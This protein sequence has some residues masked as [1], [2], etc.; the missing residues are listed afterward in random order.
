MKKARIVKEKQEKKQDLIEIR[1]VEEM[2]S[3]RF[4]K[5]LKMS[6]KKIS[7][8]NLTIKLQNYAI[9]L[10]EEFV[11]KK[12]KFYSLSRIKRKEVQK[13]LKDQLRKGYIQPL[14]LLQIS[15]V[16]FVPKKDGKKRIVQ[17]Y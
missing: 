1:I 10:K 16:F 7:E 3:R 5:Y 14:K 11:S 2:S 9:D 13:L 4:H 6:K 15:L 8:R 12:G 17:D